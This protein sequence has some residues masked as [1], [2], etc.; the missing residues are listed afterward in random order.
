MWN[1]LRLEII[2][3]PLLI[4]V[5]LIGPGLGN[6]V[7]RRIERFCSRLAKRRTFCWIGIATLTLV[8]RAELL[9]IWHIPRPKVQ[10]EFAYILGGETFALG[11]L[12]NPTPAL[13]P[14]FE[15][16]HILVT[17]SYQS[18]YPPGQSLALAFGKVVLGNVWFGVLLSCSAMVGAI[19]WMLQG[20]M[21][22]RWALLGAVLALLHLGL[23]SYWMNSYWGGAVAAT[24]GCLVM[25]AYPRIVRLR[26]YHFAWLMGVGLIVLANTRPLE[27]A[28]AA[29]P[30][31]V[32]LLGWLFRKDRPPI[33]TWLARVAAPIA[34][35]LV[36]GGGWMAYY[37]FR[38][39]G[40]PMRMPYAE[41]VRQ[42][43]QA[44]VMLI[45][46]PQNIPKTYHSVDMEY[47]YKLWEPSTFAL[48]RAHYISSKFGEMIT[49]EQSLGV[50]IT[51]LLIGAPLALRDHR[52][53]LICICLGLTGVVWSMENTSWLHYVAPATGAFFALVVQSARHLRA[54]RSR[55][56]NAGRFFSRYVIVISFALL[57]FRVTLLARV[58]AAAVDRFLTPVQRKPDFEAS[59]LDGGRK[60]VVFVR[61]SFNFSVVK[62]FEEWVF[63]PPDIDDA[64]VIWAH[65]MGWQ[66]NQE[67]L[68]R[69][70]D[71]KAW[72]F[73][74]NTAPII[75]DPYPEQQE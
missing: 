46:S 21:P 62:T 64:P 32:A 43:Q 37:N 29:L 63:N 58:P 72:L 70:P 57:I 53:R 67:L 26:R 10:D 9:P 52:V 74:A 41:H 65:D 69:Y 24:G 54:G 42:Y 18:K 66:A 47:H 59:L 48:E 16:T 15:S 3:V 33:Q 75:I 60:A 55:W 49:V 13:W 28:V 23:S 44:P 19:C 36:I 17:P 7:F 35:C 27:G 12:T 40:H 56:A 30:F 68:A 73:Q 34:F 51:S 61:Y 45:F 25:G 11:R 4:A 39:T 20:W 50:L 71:R 22:A 14:F 6:G 1:T 5:A 8:I 2:A 38:V 31:A